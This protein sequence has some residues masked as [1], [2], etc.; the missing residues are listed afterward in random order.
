[1]PA[2]SSLQVPSSA[3]AA[4]L[5]AR[6]ICVIIPTYNNAA[7][8][9]TVLEQVQAYCGHVYVVNDGSTDGTSEILTRYPTITVISYP[10]NVGKGWALRQGFAAAVNDGFDYAITLDSDGQHFAQDIPALV[11]TLVQTGPCLIIGARNM[12]QEG[13]PRKSSFGNKF[14]NF[15]FWFETGYEV[16]DTQSGYRLYPIRELQHLRFITRKFEFEIEVIVRAAWQG[17]RVASTPVSVYYA[18]GKERITH[19]RPFAD[20]TRISLLNT[21]LVTL[22][23]VYQLPRAGLRKLLDKR[24][25]VKA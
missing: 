25:K 11:A 24:G 19:F 20:F 22:R 23:I 14:S 6:K 2:T 12:Q 10:H 7:T 16:P 9:A 15:W 13:V 18:I 8:L 5:A 21:V 3:N 4:E 1:M 17:I